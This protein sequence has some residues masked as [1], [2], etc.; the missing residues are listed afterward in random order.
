M[1]VIMT[2][3][4]LCCKNLFFILLVA[5]LFGIYKD[6]G[7]KLSFAQQ[8]QSNLTQEQFVKIT[9]HTQNQSV[10]FGE[11][12]ISGSS[13]DTQATDCTVYVDWSDLK[14]FQIVNP[15]AVGNNN[16]F[17]TWTFKYTEKYHLI[18][19]GLNELTAKISCLDTV[20]N[21]PVSRWNSINIT[22]VTPNPIVNQNISESS[23]LINSSDITADSNI[24]HAKIDGTEKD[25][26]INATTDENLAGGKREDV[27]I[28]ARNGDDMIQGGTGNDEIYGD[29]GNDALFGGLG[30]DRLT[31]GKGA[32]FFYCGM[33]LD[34]ITDYSSTDG[35]VRSS[36][37]ET[38][39]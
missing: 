13:S 29:D 25:D 6:P 15:R 1:S 30:D 2:A 12:N 23:L 9:S 8:P 16:D 34:S 24:S 33:G 38:V 37:C 35:D 5:N 26:K 18:M 7:F 3:S 10:P 28:V 31:G 32:D 14:P 22:G 19:G 17:S 21:Q 27:I 11:L 4:F 39:G 20:T 36:D